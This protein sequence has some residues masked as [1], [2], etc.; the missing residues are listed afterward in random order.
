M[1]IHFRFPI[2]RDPYRAE[3]IEQVVAGELERARVNGTQYAD[4]IFGVAGAS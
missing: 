4:F 3:R 2:L 1:R